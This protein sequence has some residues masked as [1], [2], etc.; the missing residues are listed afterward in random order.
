MK[1][2]DKQGTETIFIFILTTDVSP[3]T[4]ES[5]TAAGS[6]IQ[7]VMVTILCALLLTKLF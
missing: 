7:A 6:R 4:D 1:P 2:S 3:T 5:P